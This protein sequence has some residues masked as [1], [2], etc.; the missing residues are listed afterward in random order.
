MVQTR[1]GSA[2]GNPIEK[3]PNDAMPETIV[4]ITYA[5]GTTQ[6]YSLLLS[7]VYNVAGGILD[8][9]AFHSILSPL[10]LYETEIVQGWT[11][12]QV[13]ALGE[14]MSRDDAIISLRHNDG[15]DI[16]LGSDQT[17]LET[18]KRQFKITALGAGEIQLIVRIKGFPATSD[19]SSDETSDE[20]F[21]AKHSMT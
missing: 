14:A 19:V 15:I 2:T 21:T 11:L 10:R 4:L 1:R 9:S 13:E 18:T 17:Q 16:K 6:H 5:V 8:E 7:D 12:S 3:D 20:K